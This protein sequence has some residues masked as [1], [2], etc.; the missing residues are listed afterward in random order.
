[1]PLPGTG[2]RKVLSCFTSVFISVTFQSSCS[3]L[4]LVTHEILSWAPL[5]HSL[6]KTLFPLTSW[7]HFPLCSFNSLRFLLLFLLRAFNA[8]KYQ[9]TRHSLHPKVFFLLV[10]SFVCLRRRWGGFA[11]QLVFGRLETSLFKIICMWTGDWKVKGPHYS[12]AVCTKACTPPDS[13]VLDCLQAAVWELGETG[14]SKRVSWNPALPVSLLST[15]ATHVLH[16]TGGW[17]GLPG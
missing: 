15:R 8:F 5:F 2:S 11:F 10:V 9:A 12:V 13:T 4:L 1:M 7:G 17:R 6:E 3:S 16:S 14:A